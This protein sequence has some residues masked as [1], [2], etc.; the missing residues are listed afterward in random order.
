MLNN[1][2]IY[3][4]AK[5]TYD[6]YISCKELQKSINTRCFLSI[7]GTILWYYIWI[8]SAISHFNKP[9]ATFNPTNVIMYVT[10]LLI[11]IIPFFL[12]KPIKYLN[13][14]PFIGM[15][16]KQNSSYVRYSHGHSNTHAIFK[17]QSLDGKKTRR[18]KVKAVSNIFNH[19]NVGSHVLILRG[20]TFPIRITLDNELQLDDDKNDRKVFCPNCGHY[21]PERYNRCFE[22]S[23]IIWNKN[24]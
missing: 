7:A 18:V 6:K 14:K 4:K 2:Y 22:C 11:L 5:N 10:G 20:I 23:T 12:F 21:N 24:I 17:I 3:Q 13:F 16:T 8:S 19:Y 15:V 9:W 1:Q